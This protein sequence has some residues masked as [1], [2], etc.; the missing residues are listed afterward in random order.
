[1]RPC[2]WEAFRDDRTH[3]REVQALKKAQVARTEC[4]DHPN[5]SGDRPKQITAYLQAP[6]S[7][8]ATKHASIMAAKGRCICL[9][10]EFTSIS[11][12]CRAPLLAMAVMGLGLHMQRSLQPIAAQKRRG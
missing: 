5:L 9:R 3:G 1:M 10:A 2:V 4:L 6:S 12:P 7:P 11:L 8:K